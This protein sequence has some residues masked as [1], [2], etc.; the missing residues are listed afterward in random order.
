LAVA[1]ALGVMVVSILWTRRDP[2][3]AGMMPALSQYIRDNQ[4]Y[5]NILS[6]GSFALEVHSAAW[7]I[8]VFA[9]APTSAAILVALLGGGGRGLRQLLDRFRPWR[10]G[11]ARNQGIRVYGLLAAVYLGI[12]GVYLWIGA[13][14]GEPGEFETIL[15]VLGGTPVAVVLSL[16]V[17]TLIDEGGSLEELGWRG[18]ALPRLIDRTANPLTATVTLG[19]L[20]WAWHLPREITTLMGGAEL[21]AFVLGQT[22]FL[23]LCVALSVVITF[24][25]IRTGGSVWAG[26]LIHGGTNVWSKALGAPA[27]RIV[28]EDVR[29]I[30]VVALA[31]VILVSTGGR[32]GRRS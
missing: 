32:L 10:G 12:S 22:K 23:V 3:V 26:V 6:I 15:D 25:F 31:V 9:A 5:G 21:P 19:V 2:E 28:G 18:F 17:G 16:L 4:L 30:V 29:T 20:W 7:L 13:A 11:V 8:F 24:V 14:Y 27:N 1:I